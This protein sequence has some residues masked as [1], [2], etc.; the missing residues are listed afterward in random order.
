MLNKNNLLIES[1]SGIRG[2]Y[3]KGVDEKLAENYALAYAQFLCGKFKKIHPVK[4]SKAGAEQFNRVK[5]VI[6]GD[7][8]K[9]TKGLQDVFLKIFLNFGFE[10]IDAG[11]ASTPVVELGVR[12]YKA[13]GGVVITASHNEPEFNGWK[14]L[15]A[16]GAILSIRDIDK[17]IK[18]TK[19]GRGVLQYA[20]KNCP[21]TNG[22]IIKKS[23]DLENKYINDIFKIVGKDAIKKIQK[24]NFKLAADPNGGPVIDLI[25]KL[26]KK[27]NVKIVGVNMKPGV[28]NRKVEPNKESLKYLTDIVD[29][30]KA[31][32]GFGLDGDAD[33]VEIVLPLS[34]MITGNE[35][36]A[37][38]VE[39]ILSSKKKGQKVVVNLPTSH[40]VHEI[41]WKYGA[42]VFE[43]DVGETNVVSK[44]E[45]V[46]SV[47]GGEGSCGGLVVTPCKCRDGLLSVV[48]ILALLAKR[49]ESIGGVLDSYPQYFE[50]RIE[51]R[52]RD[53][54]GRKILKYFEDK[55]YN[56]RRVPG[57][58]G[59]FKVLFDKPRTFREIV[60]VK[61]ERKDMTPKFSQKVRGKYNWLFFRGSQT[62]P[63]LFRIIANGNDQ[64]FV[65]KMIKQGKDVFYFQAN[66]QSK[67]K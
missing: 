19:M 61:K 52:G 63:G 6:G 23:E 22:K 26:F 18:K 46:G 17:I 5:V 39:S 54:I 50:E 7:T 59:G 40:L 38:G 42:K 10:V 65:K 47:V 58:S 43:V 48:V 15:Q 4:S 27:M 56:I 1:F 64:Q 13:Q 44:M 41:A 3:G 33:R 20:L 57:K 14:L 60:S 12:E 29:K 24:S 66:E 36:M 28:Y 67:L 25:K 53:G 37:L 8:R 30:Q 35:M 32:F 55:G 21:L 9:S 31:D 62:E 49:D 45:K 34:R 11:V 51:E 2:I 16:S